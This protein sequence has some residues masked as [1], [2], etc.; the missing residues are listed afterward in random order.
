MTVT[1]KICGWEDEEN[2]W[3][4]NSARMWIYAKGVLRMAKTHS[5]NRGV[6]E[7]A[8]VVHHSMHK[9]WASAGA[10]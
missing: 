4:Q 2:G 10:L 7:A 5:G 8:V 1:D 6:L 9:H 3:V